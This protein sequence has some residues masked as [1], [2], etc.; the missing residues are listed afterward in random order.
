MRGMELS[1]YIKKVGVPE[2]A[3]RF[4]VSERAAESWLYEQ[5]T[6]RR[7]VAQRIVDNSPVTWAGIYKPKQA[8]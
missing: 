5:R 3:R 4:K 8:A 6:P 2:F 7:Q 1:E